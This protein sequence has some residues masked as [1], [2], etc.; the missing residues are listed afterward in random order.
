MKLWTLAALSTAGLLVL[1]TAGCGSNDGS[2]PSLSTGQ[3]SLYYSDAAGPLSELNVKF[4][5]FAIYDT[6]G[7]KVTLALADGDPAVNLIAAKDDPQLLKTFNIPTG[8][9]NG[10]EGTF[11]ITTFKVAGDPYSCVVSDPSRTI[12][13]VIV[14]GA[15]MRMTEA[16]MSILIDIPVV[17]GNC[18]GA[19]DVGTV[20]L[21]NMTVAPHS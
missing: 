16:G 3:L 10:V 17:S 8:D 19:G 6:A 2:A 21:G 13:K 1:G 5:Q 18:P 7:Q 11:E 15:A 14:N 4:K 9:Y 12:P 20:T